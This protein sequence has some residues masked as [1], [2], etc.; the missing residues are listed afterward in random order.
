MSY[1]ANPSS[2]FLVYDSVAISG[3]KGWLVVGGTSAGA[4]QWAAIIAIA[5]QGRVANGL[6]TLTQAN[7]MIYTL[8]MTGGSSTDFHDVTSGSNTSRFSAMK[9][10]DA[11]TGLGSPIVSSL[12]TD[13]AKATATST[14]PSTTTI[15]IRAGGESGWRWWWGGEAAVAGVAAGVVDGVDGVDGATDRTANSA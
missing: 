3:S 1:D 5:N 7:A 9:G 2:G 6:D 13:L 15:T 12:V 4:P 10:Y 8:Y 11:V 14:T